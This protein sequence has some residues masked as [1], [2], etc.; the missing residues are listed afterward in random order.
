MAA[1]NSTVKASRKRAEDRLDLTVILGLHVS[2]LI[3]NSKASV[4]FATQ[5]QAERLAT[6]RRTLE[7]QLKRLL[8]SS[9]SVLGYFTH[10][11][12]VRKLKANLSELNQKILDWMCVTANHYL[13]AVR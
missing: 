9:K 12:A 3:Q 7:S 10:L 8:N 4:A 5:R 13:V 6:M 11:V 2:G 1:Y